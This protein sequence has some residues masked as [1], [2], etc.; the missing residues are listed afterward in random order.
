MPSKMKIQTRN[1]LEQSNSGSAE[2]RLEASVC[3]KLLSYMPR[4]ASAGNAKRNQFDDASNGSSSSDI[5]SSMA[6]GHEQADG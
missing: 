5:M 2:A 6:R 1:T 3:P 4:V